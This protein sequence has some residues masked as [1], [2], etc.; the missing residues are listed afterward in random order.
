MTNSIQKDVNIKVV[1]AWLFNL[2]IPLLIYLYPVNDVFTVQIK[3]YL[4]VTLFFIFALIFKSHTK[5]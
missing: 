1:L 2:G 3:M 4:V 5:K